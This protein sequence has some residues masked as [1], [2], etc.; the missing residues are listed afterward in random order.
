MEISVMYQVGPKV[1]L[2][3]PTKIRDSWGTKWD[4][5]SFL[6]RCAKKSGKAVEVVWYRDKL[7]VLSTLKIPK[8]DGYPEKPFGKVTITVDKESYEIGTWKTA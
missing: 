1:N 2:L 8:F 5:N 6:V 4:V 7:P 3:H